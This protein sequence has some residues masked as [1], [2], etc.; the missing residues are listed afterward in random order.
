MIR[1]DRTLLQKLVSDSHDWTDLCNKVG[2]VRSSNV[3]NALKRNVAEYQID[4]SHFDSSFKTR[5]KRVHAKINKICPVCSNEFETRCGAN[6]EKTYCSKKCSNSLSLGNRHTKETRLK[7]SQ[8]LQKKWAAVGV[9][10]MLKSC[11][12]CSLPFPTKKKVKRFCSDSCSRKFR[13]T[14][15]S[16]R[17]NI[18]SQI[19]ARVASG[20]HKG[21]T[22]RN[23]LSYPEKFFK[24]VLEGNGF[25]G[26]FIT[27]H[28]IK[29][30]D[31]G[32]NCGACYFLDFYFPELK[33]D[34]E[35]DGKQHKYADRRASDAVRDAALTQHGYEV[36]RIEWKS[37]NEQEGKL[38]IKNEI[39][40]LLLRLNSSN[41]ERRS[42]E[43]RVVSS[44]LT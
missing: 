8:T 3:T 1:Y 38:H 22:T 10:E 36:H 23:I 33:L 15:P 11:E 12:F 42:E 31:L 27:N 7:V 43:P 6:D 5:S 26:E 41:V 21:W 16:Y 24:K 35:I 44:S 39:E 25:R 20:N 19:R 34:L 37:L 17:V 14:I 32:L 30:T 4:I 28:P 29:K 2:K 18:M 13:W 40:K 9:I